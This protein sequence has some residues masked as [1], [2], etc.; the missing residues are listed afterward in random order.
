MPSIHFIPGFVINIQFMIADFA[1]V[2]QAVMRTDQRKSCLDKEP[3]DHVGVIAH[4]SEIHCQACQRFMG[5]G[6]QLVQIVV[7]FIHGC[8]DKL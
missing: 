2:V 7:V 1:D 8:D 5:G 6:D 4:S 3:R